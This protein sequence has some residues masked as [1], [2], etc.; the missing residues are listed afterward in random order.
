MELVNWSIRLKRFNILPSF[1]QKGDAG[2]V[3][4]GASIFNATILSW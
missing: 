4:D 1:S 2:M 3:E